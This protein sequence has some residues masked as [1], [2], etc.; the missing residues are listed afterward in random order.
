MASWLVKTEPDAYHWNS[1]VDDKR[2]MWDGVRNY[3]ARNNMQAMATGDRVLFYHTG[4]ER[5]VMGTA[6]VVRESYPDPTTDEAAWVVVD[7]AVGKPLTNPVTLDTI[8]K[9]PELADVALVRQGRL[10]VVGL[11]DEEYDVIVG[12]GA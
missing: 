2:T 9:T 5:R 1:F 10:S 8:K 11:T 3:Q 4:D 7:L 12:L 6:T